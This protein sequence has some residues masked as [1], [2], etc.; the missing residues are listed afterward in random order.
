MLWGL[1]LAIAL[2]TLA[3]ASAWLAHVA[4][5]WCETS[6]FVCFGSRPDI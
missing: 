5:H 2:L 1:A 3:I 4:G 6:N